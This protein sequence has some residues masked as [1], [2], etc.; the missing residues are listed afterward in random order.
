[1]SETT[2]GTCSICGGDITLP[3]VWWYCCT[4]RLQCSQ[5]GA[6]PAENKP[7]IPMQNKRIVQTEEKEA[8]E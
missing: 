8:V 4:T 5:C 1:M 2:V 3:A 6:Y 7:V